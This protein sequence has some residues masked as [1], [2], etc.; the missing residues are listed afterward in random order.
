M[1][2]LAAFVSFLTVT[3]LL[4]PF[5]TF[6][7]H[8]SPRTLHDPNTDMKAILYLDEQQ[9]NDWFRYTNDRF[10]YT[11]IVQYHHSSV[12]LIPVN[13]DGIKL[14]NKDGEIQIRASGA[15]ISQDNQKL[16]AS[17]MEFRNTVGE[18]NIV[19]EFLCDTYWYLC[20]WEKDLLHMKKYIANDVIYAELEVDYPPVNRNFNTGYIT[21]IMFKTMNS[22]EFTN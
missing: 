12:V 9:G 20:W 8:N 14:C 21:K 6:S 13:G 4:F 10:G 3:A 7:S 22:L 1:K 11:F 15:Y 17:F 5:K 19:F 16:H 18:Y 2:R